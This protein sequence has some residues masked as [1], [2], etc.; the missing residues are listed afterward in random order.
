MLEW[1]RTLTVGSCVRETAKQFQKM[2]R[3]EAAD[4]NGFVMCCSCGKSLNYKEV[5][6]GHYVTR[7]CRATIFDEHNCH[8]QCKHCNCWEGKQQVAI[9]YEAF[10]VRTYGAGEVAR[11]MGLKNTKKQWTKEELVDLRIEFMDRVKVQEK[12]LG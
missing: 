5:D 7:S 10:M 9:N 12:R 1:F 2:I 3:M 8:P 4:D 11:L 6:A